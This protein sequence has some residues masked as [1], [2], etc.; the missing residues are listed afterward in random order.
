MTAACCGLQV[1]VCTISASPKT[2]L[3]SKYDRTNDTGSDIS[4]LSP[5]DPYRYNSGA[6]RFYKVE[7]IKFHDFTRILE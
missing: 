7:Q 2:E 5:G 1:R 4:K 3:N 6:T